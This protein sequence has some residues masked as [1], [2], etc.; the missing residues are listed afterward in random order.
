MNKTIIGI[1]GFVLGAA[2]G[3]VGSWYICKTRYE[4]IAQEE[5]NSVKEVF[6]RDFSASK[7][8]TNEEPEPE[9]T[10]EDVDIYKKTVN[11]FDYSNYSKSEEDKKDEPKPEEKT[12]VD[13]DKPYVIPPEEFGEFDDY[14]TISLTYYSDHI[15]ADDEDEPVEEVEKFVGFESLTHFGEYEDDSVFV[16]NDRYKCDYEI[17][18][19]QRT[20]GDAMK[21]KKPYRKGVL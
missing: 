16:R 20:Y 15:L 17:L 18:L 4:Q 12:T 8:N 21:E 11:R 7:E 13:P 3:A 19:D 6:A 2:A 9:P 5:I 14:E 10:K 1:A